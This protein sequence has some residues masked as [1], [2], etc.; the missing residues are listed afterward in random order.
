MG[1]QFDHYLSYILPYPKT[2][3]LDFNLQLVSAHFGPPK[4][5]YLT[6]VGGDGWCQWIS[7]II[8]ES[9]FPDSLSGIEQ[10]RASVIV[11]VLE[12]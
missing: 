8:K 11:L 5:H 7:I 10:P 2:S 4:I 3:F 1:S 6:D 9:A 12:G